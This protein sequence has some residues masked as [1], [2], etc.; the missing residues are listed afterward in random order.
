M[1]KMLEIARSAPEIISVN[2][3]KDRQYLRF[4]GHNPKMAGD[5]N[6]KCWIKGNTM[7]LESYR[8]LA[9]DGMLAAIAKFGERLIAAGATKT[10]DLVRGDSAVVYTIPE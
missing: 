1:T 5:R 9:S 10:G 6:I 8:G 2:A 3:W 4:F 7:T